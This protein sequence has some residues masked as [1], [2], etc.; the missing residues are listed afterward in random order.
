MR[1]ELLKPLQRPDP[2][3][4]RLDGRAW[5]QRARMPGLRVRHGPRA[6]TGGSVTALK[7]R[8]DLH[9]SPWTTTRRALLLEDV[10]LAEERTS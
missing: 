5:H 2:A 6:N 7:V 3:D 9:C 10:G 8:A 4:T 1:V